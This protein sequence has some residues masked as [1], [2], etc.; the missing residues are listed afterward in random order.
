MNRIPEFNSIHDYLIQLIGKPYKF[1]SGQD[2]RQDGE[3]FWVGY[4]MVEAKEVS[5]ISCT[6]LLNLICRYL[7]K[8]IP[9]IDNDKCFFPGS[10]R[11]W[12]TFLHA[13]YGNQIYNPFTIY[14]IGTLLIRSYH[15]YNDQG[16]VA[17]IFNDNRET[18]HSRP[19][20]AII[21]QGFI[22]PGVVI[23]S[24]KIMDGFTGSCYYE[25]YYLFGQWT[26]L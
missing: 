16:H 12:F 20:N 5:S 4:H 3:P 26:D 14:P 7:G 13:K 22:Q 23:E 2:I 15:H 25:Y 19:N 24:P 21:R 6:G 1:W 11:S 9:D 17:I 18:I 8:K 10:T